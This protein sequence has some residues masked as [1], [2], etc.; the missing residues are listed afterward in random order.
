MVKP[1]LRFLIACGM[2]AAG[3]GFA[4]SALGA[5]AS[6]SPGDPASSASRPLVVVTSTLL[7]AAIADV[8]GDAV[9]IL[10]LIPAQGCP[11]HYDVTP[12]ALADVAAARM[13]MVHDYQR[14]LGE[15]LRGGDP[16]RVIVA[17][18]TRGTQTLAEPYLALCREVAAHLAEAFPARGDTIRIRLRRLDGRVREESSR[19]Q[20]RAEAAVGGRPLLVA[21][22]QED[23]VVWAGARAE[24]LFERAE[25]TSLK[26]ID[27]VVRRARRARVQGVAGNLQWGDREARALASELKVPFVILSNYP[28]AP[29]A[30]AWLRLLRDNV[31]R[32]VS[33]PGDQ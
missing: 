17:L 19:Q 32:L 23:F 1:V 9:E 21:S 6:D 13:T 22:Y 27:E 29:E 3:G 12:K 14:P 18:P 7:G 25:E 5:P 33:L 30:G 4:G 15:K 28:D 10:T 24:V 20:N 2:V 26:G 16:G 8:A 31:D 11:G